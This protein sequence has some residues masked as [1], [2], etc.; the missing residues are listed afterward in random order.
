MGRSHG[1]CLPNS[2]SR[3]AAP[4]KVLNHPMRRFS[5]SRVTA[6]ESRNPERVRASAIGLLARRD[7]ASGELRQKLE[8]Q[9]YDR[10]ATAEAVAELVEGGLLNDAR[11]AE[12]Y[13]AYHAERGEGPLRIEHDL[14]A[15]ELPGELIQAALEA[16]PDWRARA[17]E[18]RIRRFGLEEPKT[19][20]QKA[21]QGRF[22]QY[23]GF[24]SDHIRAALG[25]DFDPDSD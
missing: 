19:W 9:G 24:S 25:P 17:R 13:V 16:G 23:R 3:R 22:L 20:P 21:K 15:L 4:A 7:F 14:K 11:F 12:H 1:R 18:V 10:E 5:R 2:S 8:H 6:E